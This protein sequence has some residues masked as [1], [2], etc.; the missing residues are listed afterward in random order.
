METGL[1]LG[2]TW[3]HLPAVRQVGSVAGD[4]VAVGGGGDG[5]GCGI[6]GGDGS[7]LPSYVSLFL[8]L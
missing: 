5:G 7:L 4:V 2:T 6:V 1:D 8:S 3:T